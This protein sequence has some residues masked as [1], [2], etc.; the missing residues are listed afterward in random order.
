VSLLSLSTA[1]Y[2]QLEE[3]VVKLQEYFSPRHV[4]ISVPSLRV[5]TQLK[6]LPKMAASVRKSGL[7]IAV[8]AAS[9]K[10]RKVINKPITDEDLF[11]GVEAAY[12][13]GFQRVKLYFMVGFQGETEEDI[14]RIVDLSFE[15][16][17]LRKKVDNKT[18]NVTAAVNWLVSKPHTP[19]GWLGQREA[20]YYQRA[21]DIIF[22]R[23]RELRAKFLSFNFHDIESS[24][25]ESAIARGD[26][27]VGDIIESAWRGGAKFDL[28]REC[29]SYSIWQKAFEKHGADVHE[30]AQR[31]FE[32][33]EI[34]PW[35]HLG[36]PK[37]DYLLDHLQ[38]A[39][40]AAQE[41][42]TESQ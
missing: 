35:E 38:K 9:E 6:L 23:K 12:E 37:K 17:Q 19:F 15:I 42:P 7:T 39:L 16:A 5:K 34:L 3:L 18:A 20:A 40:E 27:R 36:G 41:E 4:G 33:D 8:E 25:L 28:W 21:K 11:A 14:R 26:R 1:D 32:A 2:P 30:A 10:L 13:A 24:M 29:I 31:Q 22:D